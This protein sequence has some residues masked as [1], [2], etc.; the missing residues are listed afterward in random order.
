MAIY[1]QV[2]LGAGRGHETQLDLRLEA[3]EDGAWDLPG[4]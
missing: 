2:P 3:T 4:F 1:G